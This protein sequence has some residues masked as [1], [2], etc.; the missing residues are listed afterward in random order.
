MTATLA[1]SEGWSWKGPSWNQ[2]WAPR[3][4]EPSGDR[5]KASPST[6]AT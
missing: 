1:I 4:L 5:T 3:L 6:V 2:A